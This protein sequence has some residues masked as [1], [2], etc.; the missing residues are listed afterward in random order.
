MLFLIFFISCFFPIQGF[1]TKPIGFGIVEEVAIL[2]F[3]PIHRFQ[4]KPL[5]SAFVLSASLVQNDRA[6][7]Q[8]HIM[9]H[10]QYTGSHLQAAGSAKPKPAGKWLQGLLDFQKQQDIGLVA[11]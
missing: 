11:L 1:Q 9:H 7:Q 6:L 5:G 4:S 3:F 10:L 2:Y 8:Q